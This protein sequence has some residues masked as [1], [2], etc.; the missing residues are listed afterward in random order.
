MWAPKRAAFI[1]E[2]GAYLRPNAYQRKYGIYWHTGIPGLQRQ[3]L[4]SGRWTLDPGLWTLN[5]RLLTTLK[6]KTVQNFENNGAI[7]ITS[8]FQTTLSN[9]L[10]L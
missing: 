2:D 8:F 3:E 7:S 9:H 4:D 5:A 1:R 6:F 10:K